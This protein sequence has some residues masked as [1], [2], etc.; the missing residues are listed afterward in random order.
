MNINE[1]VFD[2]DIIN[3]I[4]KCE[5]EI[6][7]EENIWIFFDEINTCE[8]LG[9]LSEIILKKTMHGKKLKNNFIFIGSCNPYRKMTEKMKESGLILF[10]EKNGKKNFNMNKNNLVYKVNPLPICLIN[11]IFNFESLSF[12]DEK[13]YALSFIEFYFNKI[14]KNDKYSPK[15]KL[16]DLIFITK[17]ELIN[18]KKNIVD[19][20]IFCHQY[21]KNIYDNSLISL[22]DIKRFTVFYDWFLKYLI[23]ESPM[24]DIYKTSSEILL[25]DCLNLTIYLC[26]YL[27]ISNN[28]Y[29]QDFSKK[30]SY[31]LDK[32]FLEVPLREEKYIT[33]QFILDNDKGIVLNRMLRENLLTLFICIN[34][35]EPLIII[36]KPGSGKTLSINCVANSMKGEFSDSG[37]LQRRNGLLIYR[38]QGTKNTSTKSITK[39]FKIV[40]SSIDIFKKNNEGIKLIPIFLFDEMGF[41]QKSDNLNNPLKVLHTE[42]EVEYNMDK[43]NKIVFVGISNWKL[44]SAKMNRALYL[45]ISD[46]DE[47]ELLETTKNIGFL[48]NK[49]IFLR[50]IY[51]FYALASTYYEYKKLDL[52]LINR[53]LLFY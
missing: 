30:I 16:Y 51:F 40:R 53:F 47:E 29:R 31:E 33:K 2:Q 26:Y 45:L 32:E 34:N 23:N 1:G 9:L 14:E 49:E 44:D 28:L 10:E 5:Q 21:L 6:K 18:E 25:K 7:N 50:Y 35:R 22:R 19:I 24:N 48:M 3:F 38:Y 4:T 42:L 41:V 12:E 20:L 17:E 36:G 43:S 11:Y 8:S 13:K 15:I 37:L 46:P 39:A 52:N 27:R